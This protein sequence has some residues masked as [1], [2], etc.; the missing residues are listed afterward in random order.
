MITLVTLWGLLEREVH[1]MRGQVDY[2]SH[3][4]KKQ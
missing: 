2:C 1:D 3:P 4:A